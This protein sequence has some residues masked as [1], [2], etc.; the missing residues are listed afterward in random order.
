MDR[1]RS[2]NS[3][4]RALVNEVDHTASAVLSW[5]LEQGPHLL[6]RVVLGSSHFLQFV[7]LKPIQGPWCH[8]VLPKD[9]ILGL[10]CGHRGS[11]LSY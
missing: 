10:T 4:I 3:L 9:M 5:S 11:A 8:V 7:T 6:S 1:M 2:K